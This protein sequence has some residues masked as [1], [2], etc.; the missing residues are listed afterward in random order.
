M[1]QLCRDMGVE[2]RLDAPLSQICIE[3]GRI[4]GA[5]LDSGEQIRSDL[6]ISNA[7]L[8]YTFRKLIEPR[9]RGKYTEKRLD[10]M[11][12]AC[13]GFLL[14]QGVDKIYDHLCHPAL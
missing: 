5:R 9:F 14:Y 12:S 3:D 4:T 10:R 7:D 8:P 11:E 6:V 1:V 13:S 2:L